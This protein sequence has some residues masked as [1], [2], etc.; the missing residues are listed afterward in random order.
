MKCLNELALL[1]ARA[2]ILRDPSE[3][4]PLSAVKGFLEAWVGEPM[5]VE[6]ARKRP[7]Y[8]IAY[9][10]PYLCLR[11]T[12]Y[13]N[14]DWEA[15]LPMMEHSGYPLASETVPFRV[16]ELQYIRW[17]AGLTIEQP[18]WAGWQALTTIG[19]IRNPVYLVDW[20]VYS[21]TH[22]LFYFTDFGSSRCGAD[23]KIPAGALVD[24]LDALLVHYLRR[25]DWD[26]VAELLICLLPYRTESAFFAS[27]FERMLQAWR[28]DGVLPGPD[29]RVDE[30]ASKKNIFQT[31]YHTTLVALILFEA[32][33]VALTPGC[34]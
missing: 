1:H 23:L 25:P 19:R 4:G 8:Y 2:I 5:V 14:E 24:V 9:V 34:A 32:S 26:I 16:L 15:A 18:D 22:T 13:R 17:R 30:H 7:S 11:M 21:I 10:F 6:R 31:C 28:K 12:G 3:H 20:E 27:G 33:V 29:F